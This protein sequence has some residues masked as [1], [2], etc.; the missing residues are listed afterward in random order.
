NYL[1]QILAR[2]EADAAGA[3]EA[4]LLNNAGLLCEG[5]SSNLSLLRG[6]V[7]EIPDPERSGA[8]PGIAQLTAIE[9]AHSLGLPVIRTLLSPWEL[10]RAD[11]A[12]LSGSMRE[13]VPLVRVGERLIGTGKPGPITLRL[14][15][16][17]RRM[18]ERECP[19]FKF[20]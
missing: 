3:D 5:S 18:V 14:V 16:A 19:P 11:E 2:R 12:F 17:Y 1:E 20:R 9:A 7:L 4:L 10:Y 15:A 13:L 8:L 6:G